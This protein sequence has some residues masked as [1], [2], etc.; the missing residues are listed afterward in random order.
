MF[1]ICEHPL[2]LEVQCLCSGNHTGT[3]SYMCASTIVQH[4]VDFTVCHELW[5]FNVNTT[6]KAPK[7]LARDIRGH[8]LQL[9]KNCDIFMGR[10]EG[11]VSGLFQGLFFSPPPTPPTPPNQIPFQKQVESVHFKSEHWSKLPKQLVHLQCQNGYNGLACII[12]ML[13]ILGSK[14]VNRRMHAL[15]LLDVL[16]MMISVDT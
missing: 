15:A 6:V 5:W 12:Y 10:Q 1:L 8:H 16:H 3:F 2:S 11:T 7:S 13:Y 14:S 4:M 9:P